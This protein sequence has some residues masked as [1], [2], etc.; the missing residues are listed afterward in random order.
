MNQHFLDYLG[1]CDCCPRHCRVNRLNGESGICGIDSSIQ[2]SH[3][4]LHFGEE[5]PISGTHGSGTI[6]FSGCNLQCVFCQNYQI[7]QQFQNNKNKIV[8]TETLALEMVRLQE[9]GAHNINFVSPSHV[10]F[11]MAEAIQVARRNGLTIPIVYNSNGYDS[12]TSL[13]R[14]RGLVDIFLPDIKYTDNRLGETFSN[15]HNYA[16]V[17]ENVL[18][19]MYSQVGH[20]KTD[21]AGIAL[22][23]ILVRHLVLPSCGTNSRNCLKLLA[24][25]STDIHISLMS[26]YSP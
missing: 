20:L 23:G 8:T 2:V 25:L 21:D 6:F 24:E 5:P 9:E 11:Q 14:I 18:K 10:V 26:Q 22:S 12:V 16:D 3:I 19:E 4:G 17:I 7:S 13:Q 1:E 15:I